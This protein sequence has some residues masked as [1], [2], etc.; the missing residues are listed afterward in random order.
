[1][2]EKTMTMAERARMKMELTVNQPISCAQ[3][4][5]L[6]KVRGQV[7]TLWNEN[8]EIYEFLDKVRMYSLLLGKE[9]EYKRWYEKNKYEVG[10]KVISV[11]FEQL[12]YRLCK[13]CNNPYSEGRADKLYCSDNCRIYDHRRKE[14]EKLRT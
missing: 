4:S 11:F 7:K 10:F 6:K 8:K 14:R 2:E 9:K 1:M 12:K 13:Y 5:D 3:I